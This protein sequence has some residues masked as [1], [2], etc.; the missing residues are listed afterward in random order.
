MIYDCRPNAS[1]ANTWQIEF[2]FSEDKTTASERINDY[3]V[4]NSEIN[5]SRNIL[6]RVHIPLRINIYYERKLN[7]SFVGKFSLASFLLRAID[8]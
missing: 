4:F 5:T 3:F 7:R 8:V 6:K 1:P 2:K